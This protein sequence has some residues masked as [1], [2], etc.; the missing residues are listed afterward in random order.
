VKQQYGIGKRCKDHGSRLSNP[1][2]IGD[3][4]KMGVL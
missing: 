2:A 1:V 4:I 3:K